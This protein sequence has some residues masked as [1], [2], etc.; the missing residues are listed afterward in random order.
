LSS[1]A[2]TLTNVVLRASG[3]P[4]NVG[5]QH[6]GVGSLLLSGVNAIGQGGSTSAGLYV[7]AAGNVSVD[8]STLNGS[9]NSILD[10]S[11]NLIRVG[12]SRLV[13]PVSNLG[14]ATVTCVFSYSGAYAPLSAT[15]N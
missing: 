11:V 9:I 15:C 8:R 2:V 12:A 3:S 4:A 10:S 1:A 13:G 6:A 14:G 5:V 7:P